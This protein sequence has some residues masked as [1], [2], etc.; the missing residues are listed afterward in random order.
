MNSFFIKIMLF[1]V[2]SHV[3]CS[4]SETDCCNKTEINTDNNIQQKAKVKI[5]PLGASRVQGARPNYES[6]RYELWKLLEESQYPFDFIGTQKDF[7]NYPIADFD[8]DHEGRGGWTSSQINNNIDTWI[9]Q[10]GVPD[11]VLFSAPGGND[12]LTHQPYRQVLE[13]IHSIID[14]IQK[15]NPKVI[16]VLE[17]MAPGHSSFNTPNRKA[18]FDVIHSDVEKIAQEQTT[19]TSKVVVVDMANGF[20]DAF[21]ADVL[22]YNSIGAK[23]VAQRYYHILTS[24]LEKE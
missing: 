8:K 1:L 24:F 20:E 18:L 23:F 14:K 10:T 2:I 13:N 16:I 5:M 11:I 21:L 4:K 3:S 22:H 17:K 15:H 19:E 12:I 7:A 6:Y 9:S